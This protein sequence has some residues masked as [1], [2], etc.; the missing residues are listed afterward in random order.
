MDNNELYLMLGRL[1]GKI[2]ASLSGQSRIE[3]KL[4]Q[5]DSRIQSLE[6]TRERGTGAF[7]ALRWQYVLLSAAVGTA[8]PSLF[9]VM[10]YVKG[11]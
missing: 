5:H 2:D 1:E 10:T 7:A 6:A 11:Q 9:K 8:F 4:D 3:A